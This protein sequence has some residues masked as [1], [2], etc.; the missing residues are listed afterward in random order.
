MVTTWSDSPSTL[1]SS[2]LQHRADT[3]NRKHVESIATRTKK[4]E[5]VLL[6]VTSHHNIPYQCNVTVVMQ[7]QF[8]DKKLF[9]HLQGGRKVS[10]TLRGYD[11]FLNLVID[12]AF[13]ETNPASKHPI[14]TVVCFS[15][16]LCRHSV[17]HF[18]FYT[19]HSRQ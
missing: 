4:G 15:Y 18:D 11:L 7:I 8:M 1:L 12:E 16:R 17:S 6:H 9:V 19:G 14:G 5:A 10:G 2:R 3:L 13:E